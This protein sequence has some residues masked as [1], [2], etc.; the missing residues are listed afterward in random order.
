M[1]TKADASVALNL[2]IPE[3]YEY[4]LERQ[5]FFTDI[6]VKG[7]KIDRGDEDEMLA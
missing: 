2:S 6:G 4:F 3:Y 5:N 1:V 7:Y